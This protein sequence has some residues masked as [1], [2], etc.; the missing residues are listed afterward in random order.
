MI[1]SP[2]CRPG[3]VRDDL[4][5]EISLGTG[6]SEFPV[7]RLVGEGR[8]VGVYCGRSG[9]PGTGSSVFVTIVLL[10]YEVLDV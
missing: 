10:S 6:V 5:L 8:H 7:H 3:G 2:P 1:P 4:Y 9:F